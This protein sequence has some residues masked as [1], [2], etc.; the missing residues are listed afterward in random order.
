[1]QAPVDEPSKKEAPKRQT[2]K[3]KIN[4]GKC[5][6]EMTIKSYKYSHEKNCKGQLSERAVKAHTKPKAKPKPKIVTQVVSEVEELTPQLL[7]S[8]PV[9]NQVFKPQPKHQ[10]PP[11]NPITSLQQHYQLLQNEYLKQKQDRYNKLCPNM[12]NAKPEKR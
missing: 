7:L 3:D 8:A 4:C 2:Q 10:P 9:T 1:M 5:G 11:P 12:F 6:K